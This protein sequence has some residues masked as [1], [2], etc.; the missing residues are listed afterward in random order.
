[1]T[2]HSVLV[3]VCLSD[4]H[5]LEIESFALACGA[6]VEFVCALVDI[7]LLQPLIIEG[8][9]HFS[10][11]ALTRARRILRLQRDFE[12]NLE[13]VAVIIDLMDEIEQMQAHMNRAGIM[14]L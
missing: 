1:M 12:A 6:D 8:H 2:G 14:P 3:G 4:Q 11:E 13:T 10:G 9:W 5:A 7:D